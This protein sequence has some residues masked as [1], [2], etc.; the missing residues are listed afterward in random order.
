MSLT[1]RGFGL[2]TAGLLAAPHIARAADP[3]VVGAVA[4][5]TGSG[6]EGGQYAQNGIALA[7]EDVNRSPPLG[8]PMQIVFED[9]QTTNPGTVLAFSRLAARP[10][11]AAFLAT[12]YSTQVNAMAPDVLKVAK[13]V[14]FGGTDPTLTHSGNPWL[15]R[16]RPNDS[17]SARVIAEYGVKDLGRRKWAVVYS[18]DAFGSNG[19]KALEANLA[20]RGITPVLMQGYANQTVDFTA[21]VLA[22]RQSGADVLSSY[23][24]FVGDVGIF[25]RQ[26]RQLGV[27]IPWVGSPSIVSV[28]SM[29]LAGPALYG[30]FGVADFAVDANDASRAFA[31][32][33]RAAYKAD[34]D[35]FA[36]WTFD[37]V[38]ILARAF[39]DAG[40]T[41]PAKV[42]D[43]ILA[44][45][46]YQGAEGEYN[47]DQGGDGLHGYNIV[48]NDNG[49]LVYVRRVDFSVS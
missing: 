43:A 33:Y 32:R 31:Q 6:A 39:A 15:F 21:I 12:N 37:A 44:I 18:T 41:E 5:L 42:R 28:T 29:N 2:A 3:I 16:C 8:R 11:V 25:A 23:M 49:K 9:N 30:T 17:Y 27:H 45:R 38:H 35:L 34:P 20:A 24:T 10:E 46:G 14:M 26:L 13:P 47:F 1:R 19:A 36:S 7:L 48:R 22:V 40:G 4:T